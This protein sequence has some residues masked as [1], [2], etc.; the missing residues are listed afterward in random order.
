M[1]REEIQGMPLA[2]VETGPTFTPIKVQVVGEEEA[3]V[4][5]ASMV[6]RMEEMEELEH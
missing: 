6:A 5:T 3:V 2:K 1:K 4:V